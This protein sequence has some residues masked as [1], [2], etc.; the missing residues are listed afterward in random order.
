MKTVRNYI[1]SASY[2]LLTILLP[3]ITVPIISR[4]LGST[5]V[6]IY[7]YTN[8]IV[9]E[10]TLIG[11]LGISNY[12]VRQIAYVRA[13][14]E[15]LSNEF[16]NIFF[17]QSL[18]STL[19]LLF[20][21]LV[22]LFSD[23]KYT[24]V[25][26]IQS[27]FVI[28]AGIDV[29]WLFIGLEDFKKTVARNATVK[30]L[31]LG[32]VIIFVRSE[33]DLFLYAAILSLAQLIGQLTMFTYLHSYISWR[34]PSFKHMKMILLPIVLMFV[35]QVAN[36]IYTVVNKTILGLLKSKNQVGY[37]DMSDKISRIALQVLIAVAAVMYPKIANLF[38]Q[39]RHDLIEKYLNLS[40]QI[41]HIV[42]LPM[43]V[44]VIAISKWFVPW[45]LGNEFLP[46]VPVL[47]I[48]SVL[49]W[50]VPFGTVL[51]NQYLLPTKHVKLVTVA[52]VAG[53]LVSLIL[54]MLL[55]PILSA[56]GAAI[57]SIIAQSVF[58]IISLLFVKRYLS[59]KTMFKNL[60][61]YLFNC[62][63][64]FIV[65]T[66]IGIKLTKATPITTLIQGVTGVAVY[67]ALTLLDVSWVRP[68]LKIVTNKISQ[69][70]TARR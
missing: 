57:T 59:I 9:Q 47:Q 13:D 53:A 69:K 10:F 55:I 32:L 2:Q 38:A 42:G 52:V 28:S 26:A 63:V 8:S 17:L 33:Q 37:F 65:V 40:V 20:F 12:A 22:V 70:I 4:A 6:G 46:A 67:G 18:F 29:S 44:G 15:K 64:M 11:T 39:K 43:M 62:I 7:A 36:Q 54:N 5:G 60:A 45:F 23:R 16:S 30:V 1:Y 51:E 66:F 19:S 3:I 61:I 14:K 35:P 68:Y 48:M 49:I 56:I 25:F 21:A 27:L 58:L 24:I 31:G 41:I 34:R 50:L